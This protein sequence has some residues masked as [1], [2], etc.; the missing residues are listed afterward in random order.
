M[1][2][3]DTER[4]STNNI[5][6]TRAAQVQQISSWYQPVLP[7][8]VSAKYEIETAYTKRN[9]FMFGI[10]PAIVAGIILFPF[11]KWNALFV[12]VWIVYYAIRTYIFRK[13]FCVW[14][15]EDAI[16]IE[17]GVWGREHILLNLTDAE[18]VT[19]DTSLYQRR[20]GFA[21]LRIN[22]SAKAVHIPFLNHSLATFIADFILYRIEFK[23]R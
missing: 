15:H 22:T 4:N 10:V 14:I 11:V 7:S 3:D 8:S 20:N 18:S 12:I 16:E 5:P 17:K 2:E 13:N 6:I 9:T 23:K 21:D 19:V 1:A